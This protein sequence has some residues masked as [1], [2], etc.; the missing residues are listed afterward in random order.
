MDFVKCEVIRI[1]AKYDPQ[2]FAYGFQKDSPYLE[3]F[4]FYLKRLR[5]Q[6]SFSQILKKYQSQPQECPDNS[7]KSL[8]MIVLLFKNRYKL[9]FTYDY[10]L[11]L[12]KG[13]GNTFTAFGVLTFGLTVCLA[14]LM[15]EIVAKILN[16]DIFEQS[17]DNLEMNEEDKG[18]FNNYL[19]IILP[20]FD[21]PTSPGS[22]RMDSFYTLSV[23]KHRYFLTPFPLLPHLVHIVIEW[24]LIESLNK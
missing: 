20:F 13:F 14:I 18:S 12:K 24:P 4:N 6:G 17:E 10:C 21:P 3:L 2:R 9:I 7:G 1:P 16:M 8:G 5:E 22:P 15:F 23:D 11:L 19:D